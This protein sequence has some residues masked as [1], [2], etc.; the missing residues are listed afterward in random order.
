MQKI[1]TIITPPYLQKGDTIGIFA[2]AKQIDKEPID[3]AV[4]L[5]KN[6]GLQVVLGKHVLDTDNQFA[7]K[8]KDRAADFKEFVNN[9]DIKAILCARGG[10]G[11]I[12]TFGYID[13]APLKKKPKWLIGFSDVTALHNL[14]N[15]HLGIET[16]HGTMPLNFPKN[17]E[18]NE[19]TES[20]RKALFGDLKEYILPPNDMNI[21]GK[22]AGKLIGGNLSI[23][24][25]VAGTPADIVPDNAIL[26]I[27]EVDEYLYH[28][29]RMMMNLKY[30]GKLAR[31]K[32]II[33]GGMTD[34]KDGSIPFGKNVNELIRDYAAEVNIPA[35][36]NFSAGHQEPNIALYLG[37][38]VVLDI[39]D[40][41]TRLNF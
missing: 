41:E 32:A 33:A 23:I 31:L 6:W 13:F 26:F 10:Y 24:Q 37:R 4:N 15:C 27:E 14:L 22:A 17:G 38:N 35:L 30:S 5:L 18:D 3:C 9:P 28:I 36:F 11:T 25:S 34:I 29:D 20:L 2:P 12:R 8:D 1:N 40:T 7:G 16:I 39:T 19:S 21:K